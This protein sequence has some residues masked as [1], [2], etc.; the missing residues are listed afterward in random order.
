MTQEFEFTE[1]MKELRE[2]VRE[3]CA[4][5]SDEQ[6]VRQTMET[7]AGYDAALWQRFGSELGVFGLAVAE[8][9][10]GAGL[11]LV[12]HAI[13]VEELGAALVC[14]PVLGTLCL[15]IPALSALPEETIRA[16]YLPGLVSGE[17]TATVAIPQR[18]GE[19]SPDDLSV[20]AVS[21]GEAFALSGR[22]DYV[23]DGSTADVLFI[24]ARTPTGVALF[25]VDS[26]STGV[27]RTR[28]FTLDQ[29][30]RQATIV[31]QNAAARLICA[32]T[33][34]PDVLVQT[35][36]TATALL[37]ASQVGGGQR[38][39]DATIA[40]VSSRIQFGQA[41]GAFQ[42]IK[43]R[44][45]NMLIAEEQAR[46]AAYH[47][48]WAIQDGTDEPLIAASLAKAVASESFLWIS[49]S[50][51]QLHGGM[52]FTWEGAPQLY[53]KRA[54][55][56]SL[57]LGTAAEHTERLARVAIDEWEPALV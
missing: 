26:E 47:A 31:L 46:S 52:G 11:G 48:A 24:A 2:M 28:L 1:E 16:E 50:A 6:T 36:A 14:G 42:A 9:L 34:T 27:E 33:E 44:C 49:R 32:E 35:L 12:H 40:H 4:E 29:T 5:F 20:D 17:T 45:A 41:I 53:L 22:L 15:A 30:R 7:E 43:H 13:V 10:G 21:D 54:T 18:A 57:T 25:A 56:D 8:E 38:M 51:I 37:A 39:L 23:A 3:F 19:Y 55:A